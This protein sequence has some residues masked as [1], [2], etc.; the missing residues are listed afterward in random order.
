VGDGAAMLSASAEIM[1]DVS[2]AVAPIDE[3]A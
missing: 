2:A 1:R 3:I